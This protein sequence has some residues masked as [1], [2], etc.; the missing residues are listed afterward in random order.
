MD[1]TTFSKNLGEQDKSER[2]V[3]CCSHYYERHGETF[4]PMELDAS[5]FQQNVF[6]F[7]LL[8]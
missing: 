5:M 7:A 1:V 6:L 4:K 3:V 2:C 8:F